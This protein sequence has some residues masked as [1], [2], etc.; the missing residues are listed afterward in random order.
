M[1]VK[2]IQQSFQSTSNFGSRALLAVEGL[3]SSR[4]RNAC[5]SPGCASCARSEVWNC[6]RHRTWPLK[7]I[8]EALQSAAI[9]CARWSLNVIRDVIGEHHT[10]DLSRP[11]LSFQN[12]FRSCWSSS[13]QCQSY[14]IEL[15][16]THSHGCCAATISNSHT[17]RIHETNQQHFLGDK[18][19]WFTSGLTSGLTGWFVSYFYLICILFGMMKTSGWT[20][21]TMFSVSLSLA[22]QCNPAG[23]AI[24]WGCL[25]ATCLSRQHCGTAVHFAKRNGMACSPCRYHPVSTAVHA[26]N[27]RFKSAHRYRR[28]G[29]ERS[30]FL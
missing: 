23:K 3:Q 26:L 30:L 19:R 28:K 15:G 17:R 11:F 21:S 7:G 5:N 14:N 8:S 25:S 13:D 10:A 4:L 2:G 16:Q 6:N 29:S 22:G 12:W 24:A 1:R 27:W 20:T 18:Q 9:C